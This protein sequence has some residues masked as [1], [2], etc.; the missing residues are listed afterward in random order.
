MLENFVDVRLFCERLDWIY[1]ARSKDKSSC[2]AEQ[3]LCP[4]EALC[5][6]ELV[7][8]KHIFDFRPSQRSCS[9]DGYFRTSIR[10]YSCNSFLPLEDL[11]TSGSSTS[12]RLQGLDLDRCLLVSRTLSTFHA[13]S[14]VLEPAGPTP[15]DG[16]R[17]SLLQ[18]GC[19]LVRRLLLRPS[20]ILFPA[21]SLFISLIAL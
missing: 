1:L 13:A 17:G 6:V 15:Q 2:A 5:S 4:H 19:S 20:V 7:W 18:R 16:A 21:N 10:L 3:Q 11:S 12:D 9:W 8:S 14:V